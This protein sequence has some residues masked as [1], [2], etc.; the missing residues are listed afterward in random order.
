MPINRLVARSNNAKYCAGKQFSRNCLFGEGLD[1]YEIRWFT[2]LVEVDLCGHA[3]LAA[4]YVLFQESE[5]GKTA[6]HFE[7]PR[8]GQLSVTA[9][10]GLLW[11]DFPTDILEAIPVSASLYAGLQLAPQKIFKGKTDYLF[12]YDNEAII[13]ALKPDFNTIFQLPVRGVIVTAPGK[14]VDFCVTLF[15]STMWGR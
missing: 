7:S 11:L 10:D 15:C 2:P 13:V 14:T 6:I 1:A 8:S 4:A 3:T 5:K 9:E 12:V